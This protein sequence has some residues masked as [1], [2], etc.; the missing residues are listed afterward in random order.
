MNKKYIPKNSTEFITS[1]TRNSNNYKID[2]SKYLIKEYDICKCIWLNEAR[3]IYGNKL[4]FSNFRYLLKLFCNYI[5]I[6]S[7]IHG[8]SFG[9]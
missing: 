8:K 5:N 3:K 6:L 2:N 1:L 4:N 7:E 9:S